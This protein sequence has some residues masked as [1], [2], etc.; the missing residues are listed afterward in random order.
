MTAADLWNLIGLTILV[1]LLLGWGVVWPYI[2]HRRRRLRE[3]KA[4]QL[5]AQRQAVGDAL[6][7]VMDE[8]IER[9]D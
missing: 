2:E 4:L 7:R 9:R 3:A 8:R 6:A 5:A 1:S